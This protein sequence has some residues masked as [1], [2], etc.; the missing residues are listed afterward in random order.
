MKVRLS[1]GNSVTVLEGPGAVVFVQQ[2]IGT[3]EASAWAVQLATRPKHYG[4]L[5]RTLVLWSTLTSSAPHLIAAFGVE[6]LG[7]KVH[8]QVRDF[9]TGRGADLWREDPATME[10][11][12]RTLGLLALELERW[13]P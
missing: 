1:Y 6:G 5:W 11:I 3:E 8:E 9:L 4:S 2:D 12:Q 13:R 10:R 7:A